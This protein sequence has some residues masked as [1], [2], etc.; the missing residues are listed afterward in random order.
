M[1]K[2]WTVAPALPQATPWELP[3]D[4]L[5]PCVHSQQSPDGKFS[6]LLFHGQFPLQQPGLGSLHAPQRPQ[7]LS[8]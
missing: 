6:G 5:L 8:L 3:P 7:L 1:E 4:S 2:G